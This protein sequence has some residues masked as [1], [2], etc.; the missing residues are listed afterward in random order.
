MS[1]FSQK[2]DFILGHNL[3]NHDLPIAKAAFPETAFLKLP[4]IDTLF[5]SPLAFPENPYHKL[6][7]DYKLVRN[8]KNNPIADAKLALAVFYDQMDAFH[9]MVQTDP[10]LVAFFTFAF[11]HSCNESL[12]FN[13]IFKFFYALS[14]NIPD[15][16]R[17]KKIFQTLSQGKVCSKGLDGVWNEFCDRGEK[18]SVLAYVLSWIMVS[19]GN[20]IIPPWV[21]H[22]FTEISKI[23][24][25]LRYGCNNKDCLYCRE[26]NDSIKLL[27]KYFGFEEYRTLADGR[28][29]QKQIIDSNLAGNSLLAILPTGGGKSICYQIPA[30]HRYERLGELSLVISPLKALMK[31]QV[32]NLNKA[33]GFECAAAINGSLTLP[34]RGAVMEKVRLGDIGILYISPEQLRNFSIAELIRSREVGCWIFDEA[35]CL[36]KWG[37]DFRPDYLN[38]SNFMD[39]YRRQNK[40]NALVGAFTATAKK[41]VIE[42]I[43]SHFKENLDLDLEYFMGGVERENLN[44]QVWPVTKSEKDDLIFNTVQDTLLQQSGSVIVYCSSRKKTEKLSRFL[45]EKDISSKAFHAGRSEPEKRNIQDD[46]IQGDIRV[47]CATNAFGMGIDKKDIRLVIHADIPGSLENY[48][49]EAGRAGRDMEPSDCILLYEQEDIEDQFALNAFSRVSL[50]DI[51]RILKILKQRGKKTPDIIITPGEIMRLMGQDNFDGNDTA[52]RIGVSWLERKGFVERSFNQTLFFNGVPLVKSMEDAQKKINALNLSKIMKTVYQTILETLFNAK[53]DTLLSADTILTNLGRIDGLPKRYLDSRYIITLLSEMAATGLIKE[54]VVMTA[55]IRPKGNKSSLKLFNYFRDA[56]KLMLEIMEEMSPNSSLYSDK[57]DIFNLRLMSQRLKDK[58]FDNINSDFVERI[59]RAMANDRGKDQGKSL[60]ITGRKGVDQRRVYVKFSWKEIKKRVELRHHISI[61]ILEIIISRLPLNLKQGRAEVLSQFFISDIIEA[62][63]A[64]IFL[65]NYSGNKNALIE[66]ALLYLHDLKAITLQNGLGVFRQAMNLKILPE[67]K[68]RRY[69]KGDYESLSH[70][71][72]QK[73]V[74]VHMM[75]KYAALGLEKIKTAMD[76]ISRYF[77][78]SYEN[79]I[80]QYFQGQEDIIHTAMTAQAFQDIIQSLENSVQE[81]IVAAPPEKN[82]LVLA[83]PGSGKTKTIVHRCAWLIKAKSIDPASILVLCFNHQAMLELRK[84]IR[85]LAGKSANAVTAMTYHG[86]AMR[87]TGRSFMEKHFQLDRDNTT[88]DFNAIIDEAVDILNGNRTVAG[89]EQSETREYLLARY[90]YI[91]V[92][93]Y[94]DIDARQYDFISALTGRLDQDN[95]SKISI[96]AV[97]DDDQSIYGFR[98]ANV[99]FIKKFEQDY[100]A[101][102]FFMVENYRS[103]HPIIKASSSLISFNKIR[104]KK[105]RPLC[106]NKKRRAMA[107]NADRIAKSNLVQLVHASDIESQACFT[108]Q[109]IK[110]IMEE[111]PEVRFDDFAIISRHGISF[112]FLVAVRMAL[113]QLGIPF[114]YSIKSSSGFPVFQIREIQKFLLF[115]DKNRKISMT[116]IDLKQKFLKSLNHKNVWTDYITDIL[117]A[118]CHINNDMEISISRAKDFAIETL[119]EEKKE[120]KTGK[121]VLLGTIHSVKGMEFS[122]VFILDGGW[123]LN[124]IEEERRLY[125]VG[126]TRAKESLYLCSLK[127]FDNPHISCL[128]GNGYVNKTTIRD[129][130]LDG[131][132]KNITISIIGMKDL[133]ISYAGFR[134]ENHMIHQYLCDLQ[135][136]EKVKLENKKERIEIVNPKNQT[137]AVLSKKGFE[138]WKHKINEIIST[139]VLGII[140]REPDNSEQKEFDKNLKTGSWELP[141]IEVLHK[142]SNT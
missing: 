45:N 140:K 10:G 133:Y 19:G 90:R 136:G 16:A 37:H 27:K 94:Q 24:K 117:E 77:T 36:S 22:E 26:N 83:G 110:Q 109:K 89:I 115:L 25:K 44:Y 103:S 15:Q 76:F 9:A 119:M 87:I 59:L 108:A 74:Q 124:N 4:I 41:D 100:D 35:H 62:M 116:P 82:I 12:K 98:N 20:S 68:R 40:L 55:F 52:A 8:S 97:G 106:L 81:S 79:F 122:H 53:A 138:K 65:S 66:N 43:T 51:K 71:Y 31:D 3:I 61:V 72:D 99:K 6:I 104:M 131:F 107:L 56:E 18:R 78:S 130:R 121:G 54:G 1:E 95:D 92:D 125:Y 132:N 111:L 5:L 137:I 101:K 128:T 32:D 73:N 67:S 17:A 64:D 29:L 23:V 135:T 48:L 84:R 96:M 50:K 69:T 57:A 70:H 30:L 91:L 129:Q 139:K 33:T 105:D 134:P 75:D 118:W 11:E 49:Q 112:P 28:M 46:F 127:S 13:G 123:Q 60:K 2:A 93:E 58:G 88:I 102:L 141:I 21:R 42:E 34:E 47:I 142:R 113:A 120:H 114:C 85:A 86:F 39:D 126:M 80:K 38:V 63:L 7:K 14:N